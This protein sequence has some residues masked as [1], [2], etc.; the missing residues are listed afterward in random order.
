MSST[1]KAPPLFRGKRIPIGFGIMLLTRVVSHIKETHGI[2]PAVE[3]AAEITKAA[4]E[5]YSEGRRKERTS[6]RSDAEEG[7]K[8]VA[9]STQK[10]LQ[11]LQTITTCMEVL[12]TTAAK[13]GIQG[14]AA[15]YDKTLD[16]VKQARQ[17]WAKDSQ[18]QCVSG[19]QQQLRERRWEASAIATKEEYDHIN[20]LVAELDQA[21]IGGGH[22]DN[23]ALL[24]QI[25]T[26]KAK[27]QQQ[28]LEKKR[29]VEEKRAAAAAEAGQQSKLYVV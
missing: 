4:A 15:L 27:R 16:H 18:A 20:D 2:Q 23:R 9:P 10:E 1:D 25:S 3:T 8:S 17:Q 13:A 28:A 11:H 26:A 19:Q 12:S 6:L 21:D 7:A 22:G 14:W 5:S 24:S 29:R